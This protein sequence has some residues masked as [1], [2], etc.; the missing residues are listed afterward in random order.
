ERVR[1]ATISMLNSS[2]VTMAQ[3]SR[4]GDVGNIV[5]TDQEVADAQDEDD[6]TPAP[7]REEKDVPGAFSIRARRALDAARE[8]AHRLQHDYVGTEHLLL[9]LISEEKGLASLLLQKL[10]VDR[11]TVRSAVE[12][13]IMHSGS[14][15]IPTTI[16]FTPR[17]Q[18]VI[19]YAVSEAAKLDD[20]PVGTEHLLLGML[21]EGEGI[22][23]GVLISLGVTYEKVVTPLERRRRQS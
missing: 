22:A 11:A 2:V 5:L 17:S 12:F 9:G 7:A 14:R 16:G 15:A 13:I 18:K 1:M 21:R 4:K 8:E 6:S 10:N 20:A 19:L 3:E 23:A